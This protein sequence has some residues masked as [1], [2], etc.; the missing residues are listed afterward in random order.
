MVPLHP[1]S[2]AALTGGQLAIC[3]FAQVLED[4]TTIFKA[5]LSF[6]MQVMNSAQNLPIYW[7]VGTGF[8]TTLR[9]LVGFKEHT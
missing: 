9:T 2:P 1:G 6:G 3:I 7:N 8:Q 4:M 5:P